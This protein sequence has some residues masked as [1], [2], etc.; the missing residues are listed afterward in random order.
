MF[1][2][3]D[4]WNAS[5]S[6]KVWGLP[7]GADA[8]ALKHLASCHDGRAVFVAVDD[9]SMDKMKASMLL[10]G[11]SS[12]N[13]ITFPAWDC[14]PY[15]RISPN[16][17]LIGQR[18]KTLAELYAEPEKERFILTTINAWIQHVPPPEYF[19]GASLFIKVG[20]E[21]HQR[22]FI[23]FA[24]ANAYRRCDTVRE[25]GEFA[26]RGGIIDVFPPGYDDPVR[27]DF[28]DVEIDSIKLFD[29]ETQRS[30]GKIDQLT[31][32]P[33]SEVLLSED[34]IGAFRTRYLEQFG[35]EASKDPLYQSI[36][37]G[38]H[39]PGMEHMLPLFHDHVVPFSNYLKDAPVLAD[40]DVPA[41]LEQRLEQINDFFQS[42]S[43]IN[44]D[45]ENIWRPLNPS[46]LYQT[47]AA[48]DQSKM[49][50][51]LTSRFSKQDGEQGE[52]FDLEGRRGAIFHSAAADY[53]VEA[54]EGEVS[55]SP[56][57]IAAKAIEEFSKD[58]TIILA[59]STE[60]SRTRM[61]ELI[62]EH[63][64]AKLVI[65]PTSTLNEINEGQIYAAIWPIEDGFSL[66]GLVVITEKDIYGTRIARPQGKRR[67]GENFL[68]EVSSLS[69]GDLVVH[70]DHGIGRYEG[71]EKI[72]T[73]GVDHDCLLLVYQGGDKLFLPVENIDLLSRFGKE[74]GDANLDK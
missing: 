6:G 12:D 68:R 4:Q 20:K 62:A 16:G 58:N 50:V 11:V 66:P 3:F 37:E 2:F 49:I 24:A 70:V 72:N 36:S 34:V 15:D 41:A 27:I 5:L 29:A 65:R 54:S 59:A 10:N 14:L 63:L 57:A 1:N 35:A 69:T 39:H 53:K 25:P 46:Q 31:L 52:G 55:A 21:L 13:I 60:G 51:H 28:F 32:F 30:K 64:P 9:A 38:R 74:G 23:N 73:G 61:D 44:D 7:E 45:D 17:I 26:V 48:L 22:E 8:F 67:K 42:R 40:P 18:L 47:K 33:V 43:E 71:L 19:D 56:S